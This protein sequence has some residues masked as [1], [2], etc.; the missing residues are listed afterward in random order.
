MSET[1]ISNEV[2]ETMGMNMEDIETCVNS[3][4]GDASM[5]D[6]TIIKEPISTITKEYLEKTCEE[7]ENMNFVEIKRVLKE[8]KDQKSD[9]EQAKETAEQIMESIESMKKTTDD[10]YQLGLDVAKSDIESE[11]GTDSIESFLE[12]YDDTMKSLDMLIAKAEEVDKK[13]EDIPK[14]TTFLSK[15]M[16]EVVAK[17]KEALDESDPRFKHMNIYYNELATIFSSRENASYIIN[18]IPKQKIILRRFITS[19][20]KDRTGS[21][22]KNV[23]KNVTSAF[24]TSFNVNQMQMFENYLKD[25]YG[26]ATLAFYTLYVL[27]QIYSKEKTTGKYGKHKWVEVLIMN[28]MDILT[29][30]YDLPGGKEEFD[31]Q[32]LLIKEEVEKL[33]VK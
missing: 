32:L 13:F 30:M 18:E 24:C 5:S 28:V 27:Y 6:S 29:D 11:L 21:V 12:G 16:L 17:N 23:Q 10:V 14:T 9:L 22:L 3:T 33:L 25:L 8:F 31:K 7:I 4:K 2:E 1:I 19:M 15:S 20:K 26:D